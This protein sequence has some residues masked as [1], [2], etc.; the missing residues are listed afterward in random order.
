MPGRWCK[1]VRLAVGLAALLI[2]I[3]L[4][5]SSDAPVTYACTDCANITNTPTVVL[6]L[7]GTDQTVAYT[8]TLNLNNTTSLQGWHL[9]ITSI[10]F[11][12]AGIP[13]HTLPTTASSITGVT[14]VCQSGQVCVALPVNTVTQYPITV[15]AGN[16]APTAVTFYGAQSA[17]GIGSFTISVAIS[18]RVLANIYK[19]AYT[20]TIT[21]AFASD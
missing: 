7:N 15:P 6:T 21:L 20:S 3:R 11:A 2:G 4:S 14:V 8:L 12:T 9:T 10:Q 13:T 17:T 5:S 18:I 16:S 1:L 19:G